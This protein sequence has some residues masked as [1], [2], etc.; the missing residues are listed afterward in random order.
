MLHKY[1]NLERSRALRD[2]IERVSFGI[3]Q[4]PDPNKTSFIAQRIKAI[5]RL[6]TIEADLIDLEF[7]D[8][9]GGREAEFFRLSRVVLLWILKKCEDET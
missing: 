4:I 9:F 1:V 5:A 8:T 6:V 7:I 2:E 3:L